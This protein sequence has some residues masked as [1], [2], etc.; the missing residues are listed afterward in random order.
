MSVLSWIILAGVAIALAI[1]VWWYF[2]KGIQ[3]T[4]RQDWPRIDDGG[5]SV[6]CFQQGS[7][8]LLEDKSAPGF[9]PGPPPAE[10]GAFDGY[11]MKVPS[12]KDPR[13][14]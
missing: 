3:I 4:H 5:H 14:R 11:C 13:A 1:L 2:F 12:V 7:W 10:P 6:W 9:V 8:S